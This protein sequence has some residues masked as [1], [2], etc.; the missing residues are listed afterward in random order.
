MVCVL[1]G[2]LVEAAGVVVS[3][4]LFLLTAVT[5]ALKPEKVR[6]QSDLNHRRRLSVFVSVVPTADISPISLRDPSDETSNRMRL[7]NSLSISK[8]LTSI[9]NV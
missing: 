3:W 2:R 9:L 4:K 7:S 6:S 8:L 1:S 5:T